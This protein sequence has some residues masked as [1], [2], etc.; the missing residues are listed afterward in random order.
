MLR[1]LWRCGVACQPIAA[2]WRQKTWFYRQNRATEVQPLERDYSWLPGTVSHDRTECRGHVTGGRWSGTSTVSKSGAGF[3]AHY[4]GEAFDRWHQHRRPEPHSQT[5]SDSDQR[6]GN[7][8]RGTLA[9]AASVLSPGVMPA[10]S[11][12][13]TH[14]GLN[15][16]SPTTYCTVRL[17]FGQF[18]SEASLERAD[19]GAT[20]VRTKNQLPT[21]STGR[22]PAI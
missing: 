13:F 4:W 3:L 10:V 19:R 8:Q 22:L 18:A 2:P 1:S 20:R 15:R 16:C 11:W 12:S 17:P 6:L 9:V 21:G 14:V 5:V 7:V